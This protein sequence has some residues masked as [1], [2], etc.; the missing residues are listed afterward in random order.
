MSAMEEIHG[1]RVLALPTSF[2]P[3]PNTSDICTT[4]TEWQEERRFDSLI[5]CSQSETSVPQSVRPKTQSLDLPRDSEYPVASDQLI[6]VQ[7]NSLHHSSQILAPFLISSSQSVIESINDLSKAPVDLNR[8][9]CAEA[10]GS[11]RTVT[12]IRDFAFNPSQVPL[13]ATKVVCFTLN[14]PTRYSLPY[15]I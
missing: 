4:A 10:T 1:K 13:D 15:T 7:N 2:V 9:E 3:L 6:P 8:E 5:S 11:T 14:V 12:I